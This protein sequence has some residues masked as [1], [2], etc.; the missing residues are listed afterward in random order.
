MDKALTDLLEARGW[1][2]GDAAIVVTNAGGFR[3]AVNALAAHLL[4]D[5][6]TAERLVKAVNAKMKA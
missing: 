3:K 2:A 6:A 4:I 1:T 5:A